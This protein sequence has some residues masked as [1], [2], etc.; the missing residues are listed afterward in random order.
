M[1][2]EF[3]HKVSVIQS[4]VKDGGW[5]GRATVRREH[6]NEQRINDRDQLVPSVVV[7]VKEALFEGRDRDEVQKAATQWVEEHSL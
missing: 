6:R 3:L 2:V 4:V 1:S 5:V 7:T